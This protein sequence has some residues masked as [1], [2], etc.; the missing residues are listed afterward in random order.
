VIRPI[1][2]LG[3]AAAAATSAIAKTAPIAAE[4]ADIL[5]PSASP[6]S[7]RS[8]ETEDLARLRDIGPL[9]PA[10]SLSPLFTLSPDGRR[11]AFQLRR[12]D[13]ARNSYCLAMIVVQLDGRAAPK[14]VD[15][16]GELLLLTIDS[17]GRAGLSTGIVHSITPRWSGDGR[18]IAFLKRDRGTT[19]VWRANSDGS[20]SARL[21]N[22][23][24]DVVDFHLSGREKIVYA[25]RPGLEAARAAAEIEGRSGFHYDD[26]FAPGVW[27]RPFPQTPVAREAHVLDLATGSTRSATADEAASV[28]ATILEDTERAV[29]PPSPSDDSLRISS[30]SLTGGAERGALHAKNARGKTV[31]CA[32]AECIGA[33]KPWWSPERQVRFFRREGWGRASTG[34]YQ[35]DPGSGSVRR[36]YLTRDVLTDCATSGETILCLREASLQP[37]RLERLDLKTGRRDTLFDPNPEFSSFGLGSVQRLHWRNSFGLEVLGDLVLPVGYKKGRRYP[38]I[39]VQYDTRGFLRGGTGDEYPI[40]AFANRGYAVLSVHR[41]LPIG[42]VRGGRTFDEVNRLD[43]KDFADRRSAFSGVEEGVRLLIARG[44][45]EPSAIGITGFSDGA[46]QT[47]SALIHSSLFAAAAM[48]TCCID[49]M[50]PARVGPAA[51]RMFHAAGFPRLTDRNEAFWKEISLSINAKRIKT[52]I[53]LQLADD[54]YLSALE[55][56][57]ALREVGAPIDMYVFPGEHHVKWQPAHR[58]AIYRRSLDWFDYWL[59]KSRSAAPDRQAELRHWDKLRPSET[60]QP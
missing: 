29:R 3:A 54:E 48:S 31:T 13:P 60:K 34:I 42:F 46:T 19:Q 20:G 58:L 2:L 7:T 21:T 40:Q 37:R 44:I 33:L 52:P 47:V 1:F 18:W 27:N 17:P 15:E 43:L 11:A 23:A 22:A 12:G 59:R 28:G 49:T 26:R 10:G 55:S 56:Y 51:A 45:A 16:G 36:I 30:V 6:G 14:I 8:L 24:S 32:P 25:T 4:C 57:T 9:D 5:P 38:T 39:I 53:L 50:L 41:P 35:W